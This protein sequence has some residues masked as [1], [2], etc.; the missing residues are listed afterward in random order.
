MII[1]GSVAVDGVSLTINRLDPDR[2]SVSIIPHTAAQTTI[3]FKQKG[4]P[5]NIEVDLIGQYVEKFLS[6]QPGRPAHPPSG[7]S[8][9]LLAKAGYVK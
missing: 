7:V 6:N 9:E 5:V 4:E 2:F 3:G 1:K 8:M